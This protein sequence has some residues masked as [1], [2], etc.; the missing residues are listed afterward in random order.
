MTDE[1]VPESLDGDRDSACEALH[2]GD[3]AER[4][5]VQHPRRRLRAIEA[6]IAGETDEGGFGVAADED[7]VR[8]VVC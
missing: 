4:V 3:P 1:D 5:M 6:R 7:D 2:V 8:E